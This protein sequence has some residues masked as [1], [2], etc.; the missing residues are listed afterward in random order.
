[1]L[2]VNQLFSVGD[3]IY[4]FC[5]GYFGRDN[6]DDKVCVMVMSRYA[7]FESVL[8]DYVGNAVVLNNPERFDLETINKWK[9]KDEQ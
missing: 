3:T 1:M 9:R 5:N 7:V 6:Y 4:G 8:G 2:N